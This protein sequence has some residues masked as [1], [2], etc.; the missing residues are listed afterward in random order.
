MKITAPAF[1]IASLSIAGIFPLAGFWSKDEIVAATSHHPVFMFLTLLIAFMTAF[2]MWRL[3]FLTFFGKPRDAHRYEH[4]HESPKNM[5]Y[6]LVFL[7]VLSVGAGWVGIPGVFGWFSEFVYHG[8]AYHAHASWGLMGLSTLVAVSGIFLA[9]LIYYKQAISADRLADKFRPIHT[10][11]YNKYY[12]DEL[13]DL[14]LIR[15]I[16]GLS[17]FSW[18]FD[19]NVVDGLVNLVGWL[20]VV[21]SDIKMWFDKWIIDGIVNGSGWL[22]RSFGSLL[23]YVQSGSMQFYALFILI[24]LALF[25][26][27]KWELFLREFNVPRMSIVF[28]LGIILLGAISRNL[29]RVRQREQEHSEQ[30]Q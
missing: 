27:A 12:F 8:E 4:A 19:A 14:I 5:A 2:Y 25:A 20:T 21:W 7:A 1:C 13:Y 18:T 22:V 9:W 28:V 6:P 11:L 16:L 17:R 15:P 10:L 23:R 29:A 3:C 26:M 30:E 24:G